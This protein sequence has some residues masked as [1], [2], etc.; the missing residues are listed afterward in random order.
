[1]PGQRP[2]CLASFGTLIDILAELNL[3]CA[4]AAAAAVDDDDVYRQGGTA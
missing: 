1:M 4:V 2:P 3:P